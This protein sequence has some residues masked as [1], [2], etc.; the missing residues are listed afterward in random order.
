MATSP[1]LFILPYRPWN[2]GP[3]SISTHLLRTFLT[4]NKPR[5]TRLEPIKNSQIERIRNQLIPLLIRMQVIPTL[6]RI[7]QLSGHTLIPQKRIKIKHRVESAR[8]AYEIV[9]FLARLFTNWG[10][11]YL[12]R[13]IVIRRRERRNRRREERDP[14]IVDPHGDLLIRGN[15]AVVDIR[16]IRSSCCRR[17]QCRSRPRRSWRI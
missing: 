9:D 1:L 2:L 16:L 12:Q 7:R 14:S 13:D 4:L 17:F 11:V 8:I 6:Q 3:R 15:Q 10:R 5:H